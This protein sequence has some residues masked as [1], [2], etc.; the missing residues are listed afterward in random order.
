MNVSYAGSPIW[1]QPLY[2]SRCS[3]NWANR[4]PIGFHVFCPSGSNDCGETLTNCGRTGQLTG[5][6]AGPVFFTPAKCLSP[7]FLLTCLARV[8]SLICQEFGSDLYVLQWRNR[9]A[10]GTYKTVTCRV[11]PRLWV[12]S[13]PG[14]AQF[15]NAGDELKVSK[16]N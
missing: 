4:A 6:P 13:S 3:T 2:M 14:A 5:W 8:I 11:M 7:A 12:R 1:Q 16:N 15:Y 10:R 9:S